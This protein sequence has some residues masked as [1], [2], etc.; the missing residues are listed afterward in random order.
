MSFQTPET[1]HGIIFLGLNYQLVIRT[2]RA[3][4]CLLGAMIS[5]SVIPSIVNTAFLIW[6]YLGACIQ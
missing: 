1:F 4:C 5:F 6:H 2:G 3:E